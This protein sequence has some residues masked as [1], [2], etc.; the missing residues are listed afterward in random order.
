MS[1]KIKRLGT[2]LSSKIGAETES[3]VDVNSL[4]APSTNQI[5]GAKML[6]SE[7]V[8]AVER[9]PAA[10]RIV[11]GVAKDVFDNGFSIEEIVEGNAQPDEKLDSDFQA[12]Y[13]RLNG[14]ANF[15]RLLAFARWL[16]WSVLLCGF[17]DLADS[18]EEPLI[19]T[20]A[21]G[22]AARIKYIEPYWKLSV[23]KVQEVDDPQSENDGY[24]ANYTIKVTKKRKITVDASR[25]VHCA[26]LLT[27]HR[28][29]G[30]SQI[31]VV[32]DD[33]NGYRYMRWGCY[34]VMIMNGGGFPDVTLTD[35]NQA[36]IDAFLGSR[37]FDNLNCKANFVHNQ[38]Q[39]LE[40]KGPAN[41]T[42]N[43]TPYDDIGIHSLSVGTGI[44]GSTLRGVEAG[45]VTGS[46]KN[47]ND[48]FKVVSDE[49]TAV[50]PALKDFIGKVLA[51]LRPGKTIKF[52]VN[53]K[54][55][56]EPSPKEKA[57]LANL[58]A[59]SF[60]AGIEAV[61]AGAASLNEVRKKNGLAPI[62]DKWADELGKLSPNAAPA[63]SPFSFNPFNSSQYREQQQ[64]ESQ[65]AT[66]EQTVKPG[67][68]PT[69]TLSQL[70][71]ELGRQVLSGE[72]SFDLA[73]AKGKVIV[74]D[75]AK[76]ER[77]HALLY[78]QHKIGAVTLTPEFSAQLDRQHKQ[79]E[80][81]LESILKDAEA[82]WKQKQAAA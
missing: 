29:K 68:A 24:P 3:G 11:F 16:G 49:Q 54:P 18:L 25:V 74:S 81:D 2:W 13:E 6:D 7:L 61:K 38:R 50:E 75:F 58:E 64:S 15:T 71:K 43:P 46:E 65:L 66:E 59:N 19:A 73:L 12:E 9:E 40:F 44:P 34:M 27:E 80:A 67:P 41:A 78:F 47:T 76:L 37:Q 28:W 36:E 48:Y 4:R 35:A 33:L 45:A 72:L 32:Y 22:A 62:K 31:Q 53:W 21:A 23:P 69:P 17:D 26:T 56:A 20:D 1:E 39:I 14:K 57:E 52:R 82:V 63:P 8:F 42:I 51:Y 70:V 10:F 30:Q 55:G 77:Q 60:N 5:F 79:Y